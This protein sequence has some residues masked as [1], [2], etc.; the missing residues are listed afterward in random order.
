MEQFREAYMSSFLT[1]DGKSFSSLEEAQAN[2]QA[3]CAEVDKF[4]AF[5]IQEVGLLPEGH[6][7]HF[8]KFE[9]PSEHAIKFQAAADDA[10]FCV[11]DPL[12]GESRYEQGKAAVLELLEIGL[13]AYLTHLGKTKIFKHTGAVNTDDDSGFWPYVEIQA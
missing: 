9:T 5:Y 2:V 11:Y 13:P 3:M 7:Q 6:W 8:S 12:S 10:W 1:T 4:H